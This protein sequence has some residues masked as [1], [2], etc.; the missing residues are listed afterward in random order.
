MTSGGEGSILSTPTPMP[1]KPVKIRRATVKDYEA[2]ESIALGTFHR[3]A[4]G[5]SSTAQPPDTGDDEQ[6][7]Q[8]DN[9]KYR[10]TVIDMYDYQSTVSERI[11]IGEEQALQVAKRIVLESVDRTKVG[12]LKEQW[13][14]FGQDVVITSVIDSRHSMFS[15]E[16]IIR[17]ICPCRKCT[18][19]RDNVGGEHVDMST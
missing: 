7:T 19:S 4:S 13:L 10:L 5:D 9:S 8:R 3:A 16:D 14:M 18:P 6:S 17:R 1:I 12:C 2:R 15:G 11:V